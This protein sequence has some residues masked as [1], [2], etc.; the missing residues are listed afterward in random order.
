MRDSF[1]FYRT[2]YNCIKEL[3]MKKAHALFMAI[4]EYVFEQKEPELTGIEAG[5]FSVFRIQIDAN[6]KKYENGKKGGR[7]KNQTE[8]TGYKNDKLNNNQNETTGFKNGGNSENQGVTETEPNENVNVNDNVNKNIP[9]ISPVERFEEFFNHYP[10][11][12]Y[13]KPRND[14]EHAYINTLLAGVNTEDEF[15]QAV[16]NY[17]EYCKLTGVYARRSDNF[18]KKCFFEDF[19]PGRYKKPQRKGGAEKF[20]DFQQNDYDFDALEKELLSN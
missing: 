5:V 13:G 11:N 12:Q 20:N 16:I 6:N 15:V 2:F 8:T 4:L 14:T 17:A 10:E 9:P 1:I 7:P 3:E 18:F 19:L